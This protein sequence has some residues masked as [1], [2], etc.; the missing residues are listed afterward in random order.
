MTKSD[1][2]AFTDDLRCEI[3]HFAD[4]IAAKF[5]EFGNKH[6][7]DDFKN[8]DK[9]KHGLKLAIYDAVG[10]DYLYEELPHYADE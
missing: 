7:I 1:A 9:S 5:K 4:V 2:D 8:V 10:L 6:K 3:D